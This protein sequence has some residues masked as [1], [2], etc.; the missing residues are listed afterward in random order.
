MAVGFNFGLLILLALLFAGVGAGLVIRGGWPRRRG[1]E[2]RCRACDYNLTGLTSDRCPECGATL[3]SA[4][5]VH[6]VR[7]R[8]PVMIATGVLLLLLS[9]V[10]LV[11]VAQ[12][13][14]W[15][16]LKPTSWLV[17]DLDNPA[18][19]NRAW[20]ELRDRYDAGLLVDSNLRKV[21]ARCLAEQGRPWGANLKAALVEFLGLCHRDGVLTPAE[22]ERFV[23]QMV[24]LKLEVRAPVVMGDPLPYRLSH[25]C[26][27]PSG[28]HWVEITA[29][30]FFLDGQPVGPRDGGLSR[31]S[32]IGAGGSSG[33]Q[34]TAPAP[35]R[36]EL[37]GTA[38]VRVFQG[39]SFEEE[40]STLLGAYTRDVTV[41]FEVLAE[42]PPDLLEPQ[43]APQH[44]SALRDAIRIEIECDGRSGWLRIEAEET[45]VAVAFDVFLVVDGEDRYARSFD[46]QAGGGPRGWNSDLAVPGFCDDPPEQCTVILRAS[47]RAAKE[48]IDIF[49]Y[50]EGE[51][52]FEAVPVTRPANSD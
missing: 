5:V 18:A 35:G 30:Q 50:W 7:R 24:L 11:P 23:Q 49:A 36:H 19:F 22:V 2:P 47:Q 9:V 16:A 17:S 34:T 15:Y 29:E 48:S 37:R 39:P 45:P 20:R 44:A 26:R 38:R 43:P 4:A 27:F 52:V 21:V 28:H 40:L 31:L 6:G 25:T 46:A 32:G 1:T 10:A 42:A 12:N 13:I 14:D 33:R 41:R 3:T 8:R 51:L